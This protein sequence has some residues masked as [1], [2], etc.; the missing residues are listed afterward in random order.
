VNPWR[1]LSKRFAAMRSNV[2]VMVASGAGLLLLAVLAAGGISWIS[3][4]RARNDLVTQGHLLAER[5]A[6][7]AT[8]ALLYGAP[9]NAHAATKG[10][11]QF[12]SVVG[13]AVYNADGS[14]LLQE[15]DVGNAR[16][17]P[18]ASWSAT[19][20][21][22]MVDD[23]SGRWLF[24]TPV[25]VGTA[26]AELSAF[27]EPATPPQYQGQVAV[28]VSKAALREIARD[29]V[30]STATI[31]AL[32]ALLLLPA[33]LIILRHI[34]MPI[35]GLARVMARTEAGDLDARAP[36]AGPADVQLMERAFNS[37]MDKLQ[38]RGQELVEARDVAISAA[39][40]KAQFTAN[41]THEIRTP[42]N[43]L[44]GML[45][46]LRETTLTPKQLERLT[47]AEASGNTLLA[48]IND[49]LDFSRLESGRVELESIP[50]DLPA[51]VGEVA[52]LFELQTRNKGIN[53][54]VAI[55]QDVPQF[56][57]GDPVRLRHQVHQR[58]QCQCRRGLPPPGH[59]W[60]AVH[61]G[62]HGHRHCREGPRPN[63]PVLHAGR[64]LYHARVR[65]LRAGPDHY[66]PAGGTDGG[67]N[68]RPEHPGARQH[69]QLLAASG[70]RTACAR[71]RRKGL[72]RDPAACAPEWPARA[73]GRRQC[74]QPAGGQRPAGSLRLRSD[75][76]V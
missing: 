11:L 18:A 15:G 61:G 56:V 19:S 26:N 14:T 53:L 50:F 74:H 4:D 28:A 25:Y 42:L 45:Q 41:V 73:G 72:D 31:S 62:R 20:P 70:T 43:G 38:E 33:L 2:L 49:I 5:Y 8:L 65:W 60:R 55:A 48:L 3:V 35:Q 23:A 68:R 67:R 58:R 1:A 13:V 40:L 10:L 34:S 29:I 22:R 21:S 76:R 12:P 7:Q 36:L 69:L 32:T 37:M 66:P 57:I 46:L 59:R 63:L 27:G 24:Q 16:P 30:V 47:I 54:N 39:R 44:L 17:V 71:R 6:A 64:Q 52:A 9:D 75:R 51:K